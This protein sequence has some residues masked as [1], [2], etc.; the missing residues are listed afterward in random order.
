MDIRKIFNGENFQKNGIEASSSQKSTEERKRKKYTQ[1]E[2]NKEVAITS[3]NG[4]TDVNTEA[5]T[6][7]T[8]FASNTREWPQ[9]PN[10]EQNV[11]FIN[12]NTSSN[13]LANQTKSTNIGSSTTKAYPKYFSYHRVTGKPVFIKKNPTAYVAVSVVAPKSPDVRSNEDLELEHE[14]RQLK[15]W[16]HSQNLKNMESIRS[17]WVIDNNKERKAKSEA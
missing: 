6:S 2:I 1:A 11:Q 16:T 17:R 13:H 8:N 12:M 9:F 15:P 3:D 14:L 10:E 4:Q 5:S 7:G